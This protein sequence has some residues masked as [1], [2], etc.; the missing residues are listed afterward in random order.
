MLHSSETLMH[1]L[2]LNIFKQSV[3]SASQ[4]WRSVNIES[5][6]PVLGGLEVKGFLTPQNHQNNYKVVCIP[7]TEII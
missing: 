7:F 5:I 4:E 3:G 1:V 6:K 2:C